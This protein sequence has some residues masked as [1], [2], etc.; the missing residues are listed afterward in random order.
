[1][2]LTDLDT[3]KAL[4]SDLRATF[5]TPQGKEVMRFLEEACGWYES[6]FDPINR[7]MVLINAG[8]REVVATIKTLLRL[9]ASQVVELAKQKEANA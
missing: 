9:D 3:V 5:E 8:K 4:Q 1:M 6:V 7:D 2:K